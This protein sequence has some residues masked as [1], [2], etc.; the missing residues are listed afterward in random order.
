MLLRF[1][2]YVLKTL[3]RHRARTLLTVSGTAVALFVYCFVDAVQRGLDDLTR[4]AEA[5]RTLVVFQANKFCPATSQLPQDYQQQIE[6]LPGVRD[7][8]PIQVFTNNCRASLDVVVF[9]GLPADRLQAIRDFELIQGTWDEFL[10]HQDAGVVGQAV[11]RRRNL[12]PGDRFSIG[13]ITITVAGIYRSENPAE[14]N[15]VY[16]HLDFLQRTGRRDRAGTV[17]QLEVRLDESADPAAVCS[18]ID[19]MFR[20]GPIATDTSPKGVFQTDSL[21]DLTELIGLSQYLGYTCLGLVLVLVS[22]T[23]VMAVQDRVGEHAVLQTLGFSQPRVF[24]LVLLES[25]LMGL[26]G[27]LVGVTAAMVA[28][29]WSKMAVGAEAVTIAFTP[30]PQ[31]AASGL[32]LATLSGLLAGVFPAWQAARAE[33]VAALRNG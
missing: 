13:E 21:A 4:R 18:A 6:R 1:V 10:R 8:T 12:K 20:G 25:L 30:S 24:Q 11:A 31:L 7:A 29:S 17:T 32:L 5:E 9:Y 33:I 16:A 28:L 14:E 2:P 19:D 23:T 22:T 15:Y 27:G 3:W 26:I